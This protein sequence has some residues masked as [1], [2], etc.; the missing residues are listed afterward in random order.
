MP[1]RPAGRGHARAS[2]SA[3][4]VR[5]AGRAQAAAAGGGARG[6]TRGGAAQISHSP[7]YS[8]FQESLAGIDTV[9]AYG[10]ERRFAADSDRHVDYNHRRAPGARPLPAAAACAG[11]PVA[12]V[13]EPA[14]HEASPCSLG[15]A[16]SLFASLCPLAHKQ[17]Q[18]IIGRLVYARGLARATA[19]PERPCARGAQ[20]VLRAAHGRPVAGAG[21][22]RHRRAAGVPHLHAGC[23]PQGPAGRQQVRAGPR[24]RAPPWRPRPLSGLPCARMLGRRWHHATEPWQLWRPA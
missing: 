3:A 2:R 21:A 4:R 16:A 9:R 15:R 23:R 11:A 8:H 18:Q 19:S 13:A 6:L 22:G 20:G 10:Y 24:A 12:I 5:R 14:A 17:A 7:I 1:R